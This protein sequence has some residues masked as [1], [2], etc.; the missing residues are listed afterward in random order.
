MATFNV[1]SSLFASVLAAIGASVCCVGPLVLLMLGIGGARVAS[2][3]ALEPLRPWFI[4]AT[5]L[6][7]G[8]AF[9]RLYLQPQACEPG[10]ACAEPIVLRRQRW[11]FWVV[12][13]A[14]IA[15]LSVPWLAPFFF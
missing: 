10:A 4:G 5:L 13:L 6:F 1:K 11:I 12:A 7:L 15:L 2:L 3:T 14:L 8:L 9:R